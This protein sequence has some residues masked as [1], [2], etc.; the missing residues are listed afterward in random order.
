MLYQFDSGRLNDPEVPQAWSQYIESAGQGIKITGDRTGLRELY[1]HCGPTSGALATSLGELLDHVRARGVSIELSPFAISSL[2]HHAL[3]PLPYSEYQDIYFLSMGD[4]AEIRVREG[5]LSIE[6]RNEYPWV[7]GLS[8]NDG[9][10]SE[11]TLFNL[12]A[13]ATARQVDEFGNDGFLMLSSGKDSPAV[14]LGLAE[15]GFKHIRC[16]TYSSGADDPEPPVA[17]DICRRLGLTHDIVEMPNDPTEMAETLVRFF[18]ASAR[19]GVDLSQVPYALATAAA[20][21]AA[22]AVFDG[23]GNDSYM[24]YPVTGHDRSKMRYRIRGRRLAKFIQSKVPVD[25]PINYL[26]RSRLEGTMPGRTMRL[27]ES[28]KLYPGA[29]DTSTWWYQEGKAYRHLDA[30]DLFGEVNERHTGPGGSMQKQ[31]LAASAIGMEAALPWCDHDLADYYFNLPEEYR[32]DRK[33]N[34]NK[35]LLRQ[36][37]DSYLDYDADA[38]GKHYFSFDGAAFI[39]KNRDFVQSEIGACSLWDQQGLST[40][41]EWLDQ[42]ESRPLLYHSLLTVFMIS[43]WHNH[44]RYLSPTPVAYARSGHST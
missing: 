35:L 23:G 33:T 4:I 18:E 20:A 13:Q 34:K 31:R 24:G 37:L 39:E 5:S 1:V 17:A 38:I 44:S 6:L 11:V 26:T 12:L 9:E 28:S 8:R 19:P 43:G 15:G 27:P 29:V 30:L 10:P 3:V 14:A 2:L 42:I 41:H 21:P 32:Y 16:V 40:V 7:V 36:M 22:G 25:S